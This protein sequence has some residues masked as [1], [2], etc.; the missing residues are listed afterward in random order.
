MQPVLAKYKIDAIREFY[1]SFTHSYFISKRDDVIVKGNWNY[2]KIS[3]KKRE[4]KLSFYLLLLLWT[5]MRV[6]SRKLKYARK[7]IAT[8]IKNSVGS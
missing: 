7:S 3:S 8:A 5:D 2:C 4:P 1:S 6:I